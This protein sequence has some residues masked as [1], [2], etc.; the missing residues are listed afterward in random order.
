MK[1]SLHA[2]HY[3]RYCQLSSVLCPLSSV[4]CP[5]SSVLCPLSS[6]LGPLHLSRTLY[7]SALFMQ[8]KANLLN[9]QMNVNLYV[10]KDYENKSNWKLSK[11]KPNT[12]P[13]KPNSPSA[14]RNTQYAIRNTNPIKPNSPSAIRNTQY[15]IRNTNPI[16]PNF[17]LTQ[18]PQT[19]SPHPSAPCGKNLL[20]NEKAP[21]KAGLKCLYKRS[22]APAFIPPAV[23]VQKSVCSLHL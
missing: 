1:L 12:N 4:L 21:L 2:S 14:I 16:K 6:V 10:T 3:T 18:I 23:L 17:S 13:I 15:A 5:L 11:N 9:A 22:Y 7:K 20:T 8:N 19:T